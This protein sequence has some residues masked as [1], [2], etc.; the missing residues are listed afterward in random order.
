METQAKESDVLSLERVLDTLVSL[1]LAHRDAQ[2]YIYLAK[3]GPH[4]EK[5][6]AN[7]MKLTK[8]QLRSSLRNLEAKGMAIASLEPSIQFSAVS[9]ERVIDQFLK[10]KEEQGKALQASRKK[11]LSSWR[12]MIE[13]DSANR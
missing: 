12:S 4:G 10:A 6:I 3:K 7:T 1:G 13:N 11:L 9:I 2:V 5:D 8:Q